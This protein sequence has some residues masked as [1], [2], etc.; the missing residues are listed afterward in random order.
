MSN[1]IGL[2]PYNVAFGQRKLINATPNENA[3]EHPNLFDCK[4][5]THE[6][7]A[8]QPDLRTSGF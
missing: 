6:A 3:I 1:S 7:V 5:I 2:R 4:W 8:E